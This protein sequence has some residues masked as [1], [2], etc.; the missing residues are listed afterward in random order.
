VHAGS[1]IHTCGAMDTGVM[2]LLY[3]DPKGN[4]STA[5][6]TRA[7]VAIIGKENV[8]KL[9]WLITAMLKMRGDLAGSLGKDL[10]FPSRQ[11]PGW[12]F[13]HDEYSLIAN[14]P[15]AMKVWTE[16]VNIVRAYGIWPVALNQSLSVPQWGND[17][18]R[19]AFASQVIAFRINSKCSSDLVPGL[20]FDPNDLPVD[21]SG[22]VAR[23]VPG[24]A[25]HAHLDT[26]TRWDFLPSEAD[27]ARMKEKGKPAPPFTTTTAFDVSFKKC[28]SVDLADVLALEMILGPA[29]NGRWQVGG[30][31][32]THRFPDSLEEL[33]SK[34]KPATKPRGR[35]GQRG[36]TPTGGQLSPV[37]TEVLDIVR[38]GTTKTGE[39][40]DAAKA[41]KSSVHD[42]LDQL[43]NLGLICKTA[44]GIYEAVKQDA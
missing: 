9:P 12:M 21:D 11:I 1:D 31:G 26:P 42:A 30:T 39:I 17:H 40:I 41:A 16:T 22:P 33:H 10:L 6:A 5:L 44:H 20:I 25:V 23:P 29:V 3:A 18:A 34:G 28:P 19:S 7:R 13:L 2:N 36:G 38:G 14:D 8:L 43:T 37:Q 32:A 4:S 24:M 35:W 27:A 15:L